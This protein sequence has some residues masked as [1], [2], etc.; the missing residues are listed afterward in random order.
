MTS[1]SLN[2]RNACLTLGALLSGGLTAGAPVA[3]DEFP[4]KPI[5]LIVPFSPGNTSDLWARMVAPKLS[6][7]WRQ[8]VIVENKPGAS[9]MIGV[10]FVRRS[11]PDGHTLL[12]GSLSTSMAK[13]TNANVQFDPQA[14]LAPVCKYLSFKIVIAT[15]AV[16][17]AK[18]KTLPDL[19]ALSKSTPDGIFFGGTG[20][21]TALNMSAAFPLNGLGMRY[22]EVNYNGMPPV[23]LAL[24]RNEVQLLTNTPAAL[25]SHIDNGSIYPIAAL[26]NERFSDL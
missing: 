11:K 21:G 10:D 22:S 14:E 16:T 13:L 7:L 2:R 4:S 17:Y 5:T 26:G 12:L 9:T 8:P 23:I 6:A 25:K 3:A 24:I 19:V 1:P 15:N 20:P 18:A